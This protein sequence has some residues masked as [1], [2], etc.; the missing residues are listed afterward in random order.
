MSGAINLRGIITA[1][2]LLKVLKEG[3]NVTLTK[4]DECTVEISSTGGGGGLLNYIIKDGETLNIEACE[5]YMVA[6]CFEIENN[7]TVNV[8][9]GGQLVILQG[10]LKNDGLLINDGI[11][12]YL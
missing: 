1:D 11:I 5:Q 9:N 8:K 3:N 10:I 12:I 6:Q 7:A 4:I 2:Q